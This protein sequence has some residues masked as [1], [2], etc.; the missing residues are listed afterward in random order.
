MQEI[1][2]STDVEVNG[3]I[4]GPY[5]MLSIGSAAYTSDKKLFGTFYAN[6]ELL[7]DA[8]ED[9][10]TMRWWSTQPEAW[11]ACRLDPK[12]PEMVMAQYVKWVSDLPGKPVFVGYP[13]GFDFLFCYWY[14]IKFVGRSPFSFSALD[15]KTYTMAVLKCGF[16]ESTKSNMPKRWFEGLPP[17][18][19]NALDDAKEQGLLFLNILNENI[20]PLE[21]I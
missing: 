21:Q 20:K 19:H 8:Q 14:M 10:D 9:P 4:P 16:K 11:A 18:T 7:P 5:S 13:A 3:P 17:H 6:L 2:V 15:I 12:P 1:F